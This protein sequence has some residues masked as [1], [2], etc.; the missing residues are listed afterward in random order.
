MN[1]SLAALL[2]KRDDVEAF[3]WRA[4][5]ALNKAEKQLNTQPSSDDRIEFILLKSIYLGLAGE[6]DQAKELLRPYAAPGRTLP[7]VRE[8]LEALDF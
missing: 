6:K 1:L 3:L 5:E 2:L 4:A 8:V 7:Q